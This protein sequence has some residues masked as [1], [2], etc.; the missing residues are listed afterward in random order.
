MS[1]IGRHRRLLRERVAP[2]TGTRPAL[3]PLASPIAEFRTLGVAELVA[4]IAFVPAA[5]I[6]PEDCFTD[7][8][9]AT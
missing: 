6:A 5:V 4:G 8:S 1:S 9:R 2:V 3:K 7:T